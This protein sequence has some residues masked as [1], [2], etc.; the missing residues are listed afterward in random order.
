MG[1][2]SERPEVD[3]IESLCVNC[4]QN[5]ITK[6][7]VTKIPFF[8]EIIIM[9]FSCDNCGYCNNELQPASTI[10]EKGINIRLKVKTPIDMDRQV[11]KSDYAELSI[12]EL[13]FQASRQPGLV[14]TVEGLIDRAIDGLRHTCQVNA[15]QPELVTKLTDFITKLGSLKELNQEFT[16]VVTD[17][18][19]N[20]F[21]ENPLAPKPDPQMDIIFYT[22]SIDENKTLGIYSIEE[23]QPEPSETDLKDEVLQFRTNC[24]SCGAICFTNMKLTNIPHF[25]DVIL[26]ATNCEACGYKTTEIKSGQGI[27]EKGVKIVLPIEGEEDLKRDVVRSE[28]C[29]LT[30]PELD[31]DI[32]CTEAGKY[33]TIEGLI[34]QVKEGL[35]KSNPFV[36]GDS[37]QAEKKEKM[38]SL[39]ERL[40]A[41]IGLT[42]ILDDPCGNSFVYGAT[43]IEHYERTFEQNE[44]LGL[45]DM[46]TDL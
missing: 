28:T 1:T 4:R 15:D 31:L 32:G 39:V 44:E 22:R 40:K 18:S 9:S 6:L 45:N 25:K 27:S 14:T 24:Y 46:K 5:G 8:R 17:P 42:L 23:E 2:L 11:V 36:T 26:M 7:M 43:N 34:E 29:S 37:A 41:P 20:S 30:I 21:I 19:G 13:S 16:L 33:T 10:Q 38:M 12:P 3:E 35:E